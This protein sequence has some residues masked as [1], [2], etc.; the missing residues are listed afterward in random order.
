MVPRQ[1]AP[2]AA[3]FRRSPAGGG[4]SSRRQAAVHRLA[5]DAVDVRAGR[6][7]HAACGRRRRRSRDL[8]GSVR[9]RAAWDLLQR[10]PGDRRPSAGRRAVHWSGAV[11]AVGP[12]RRTVTGLGPVEW[13]G[14]FVV[15]GRG[16]HDHVACAPGTGRRGTSRAPDACAC[17]RTQGRPAAP[18]RG[19]EGIPRRV[20]RPHGHP[21]GHRPGG[22]RRPLATGAVVQGASGDDL[23]RIPDHASPGALAGPDPGAAAR[24]CRGGPGPRLHAPQPLFCP[25][26]AL[27]RHHAQCLRRSRDGGVGGAAAAVRRLRPQRSQPLLQTLA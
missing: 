17:G 7:L 9:A 11:A 18:G 19:G 4:N 6:R 1:W 24:S 5:A 16:A 13:A 21:G 23:A 22:L 2:G 25:V 27:L 12:A 8:P 14:G 15:R 10:V 26:Q 20:F 3:L